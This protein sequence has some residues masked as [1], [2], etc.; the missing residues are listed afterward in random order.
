MV[1]RDAKFFED[2]GL[3]RGRA[4]GL[5]VSDPLRAPPDGIA[6]LAPALLQKPYLTPG[7]EREIR[8]LDTNRVKLRSKRDVSDSDQYFND[9]A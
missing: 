8:H 4:G 6:G 9:K 2:H 3:V 1:I 7:P 5:V